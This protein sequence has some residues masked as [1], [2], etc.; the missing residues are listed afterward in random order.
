[1][2]LIKKID[3]WLCLH[4]KRYK[5]WRISKALGIKPYEWQ[6]AF[7]LGKTDSSGVTRRGGGKT[8][9]IMLRLLLLPPDADDA[10]MRYILGLVPG[11]ATSF[12]RIT[13]W[14]RNEYRKYSSIC[15]NAGIPVVML[16][17]DGLRT[18]IMMID[19][20]DK[21]GRSRGGKKEGKTMDKKW[22]S[23]CEK[24]K[25]YI[26]FPFAIS[27]QDREPFLIKHTSRLA[28]HFLWWHLGFWF[29]RK[30]K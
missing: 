4:S 3:R 10:F 13:T 1:M 2:R 23:K 19:E 30:E 28:I 29:E 15:D 24:C 6:R 22:W 7:A 17:K 9:A 12:A 11:F 18:N 26:V 27:W 8:F 20:W 14:Y 16:P 21:Y 25:D 5:L